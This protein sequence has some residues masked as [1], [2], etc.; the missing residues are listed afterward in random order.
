MIADNIGFAATFLIAGAGMI[1]PFLFVYYF[2]SNGYTLPDRD[3]VAD[4]D[5]LSA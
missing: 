4:G 5:R 2:G 3:S 1:V